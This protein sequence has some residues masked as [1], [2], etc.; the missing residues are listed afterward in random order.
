MSLVARS[1]LGTSR[2]SDPPR[3]VDQVQG[4]RRARSLEVAT[5]GGTV[6]N[7]LEWY[8]FAVFGYFAPFIG[9]QFFPSDSPRGSLLQALG[10]FAVAYLM[11]PIGGVLFGHIGDRLGRRKALQI[12]VLLMAVPT[13][14]IGV[15]PTYASIGVSASVLMVVA[16][17]AQGLSVGGELIGSMTFL[18]ETA[19]RR[20]RGFFGSWSSSGAVAGIMLGSL[21]ATI[22]QAVL[23]ERALA[24]WGWRVPFLAGLGIAVVGLWMRRA[25]PESPVFEAMERKGRLHRRP[26]AT[27]VRKMPGRIVH[28]GALVLLSGGGFYLLF[29]WWPILLSRLVTP[30]IAHALLINTVSMVAL[31]L[32]IP[33]M[34]HVSD[35][36]GRRPMLIG[37]A[38]GVAI[39]AWPLFHLVDHRSFG[40]ALAAQLLFVV[41]MSVFMG[42][43]PATLMEMFPPRRRYSGVAV[44]YNISLAL[45][46]GTAPW[47]ATLL[48]T[49]FHSLVAPCAYLFLLAAGSLSA[50]I[51]LRTPVLRTPAPG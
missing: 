21:L 44:G 22:M 17:L 48:L 41:L 13:F 36:V 11:R 23:S 47:L 10:V 3:R 2:R 45:F 50:A 29:V 19:P 38:L 40:S 33:L 12:S 8:D 35:Q 18:T 9:T 5:L 51:L 24:S 28:A 43:V 42:P 37:G 25:L 4:S 49:T 14:A 6:G 20:R 1:V 15:M 27:V 16:R 34:G 7:V 46:G 32:L 30:P 31:L 26:V 39:L